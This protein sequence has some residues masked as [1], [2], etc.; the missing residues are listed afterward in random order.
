VVLRA[1]VAEH[2][3]AEARLPLT[4]GRRARQYDGQPIG[5]TNAAALPAPLYR[6]YR[7]GGHG[8]AG[9]VR[10]RDVPVGLPSHRRSPAAFADCLFLVNLCVWTIVGHQAWPRE[11]R[12]GMSD[13][14]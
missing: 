14:L 5:A 9:L 4:Q 3:A 10:R 12:A 11:I 13:G 8:K 6:L 1:P 7:I 2:H